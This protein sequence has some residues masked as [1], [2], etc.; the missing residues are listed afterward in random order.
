[1]VTR[2]VDDT[3]GN[4]QR[5]WQSTSCLALVVVVAAMAM[6]CGC[7]GGQSK[8]DP[9][10][11]EYCGGTC[12]GEH[13]CAASHQHCPALMPLDGA[14]CRSEGVSCGYGCDWPS[15]GS[16]SEARC[17][18]ERWQVSE[19]MHCDGPLPF[20]MPD[21]G[22]QSDASHASDAACDE[23]GGQGDAGPQPDASVQGD[24]ACEEDADGG[25]GGAHA[26][27]G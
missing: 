12:Y 27:G 17:L 26:D 7:G 11:L 9:R 13:C 23:D 16:W 10:E 14:G 4:L 15:I 5:I 24:A 20:P 2:T 18:G 1:V 22:S 21:A 6:V 19:G 3:R 25:D 8:T